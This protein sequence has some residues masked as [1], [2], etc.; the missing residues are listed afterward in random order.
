MNNGTRRQTHP[1]RIAVVVPR[2]GLVGGGEK[3][4]Y[5]LTERIARDYPWEIHVFANQW[6]S[7]SDKIRFHHVPIL[8][9]P[10]FLGPLSFAHFVHR[11]IIRF[12]PDLI[13]THE[14]IFDAHVYSVHGIPHP[15]W[16]KQIRGKSHMS[17]FDLSLSYVERRLVNSPNCNHLLAVSSITAEHMRHAFDNLSGRMQIVPPGVDL[18][19]F[20]K[21]SKQECRQILRQQCGWNADDIILLFVGMNFEIKGLDRTMTAL[22]QLRRLNLSASVRLL[23]VGKGNLRKYTQMADSLGI[24]DSVV[25]MGAIKTQ[26]ERI[27][28][29][30]DIF[31]L[32]SQFDTFGLVVLEAMAA[33]LPVIISTMVGAKDIV[34]N[35]ENGYIIDPTTAEEA[36]PCIASA[37]DPNRYV[38]L[39]QNARN[40]AK[41]HS[42]SAMAHSVAGIYS[43]IL[44]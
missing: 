11:K 44:I 43:D 16:V 29:G 15:L 1:K 21:W 24:M 38:H 6:R 33:G 5:E 32:L 28:L 31:I 25:F 30:S 12:G 27:Y 18:T 14:R 41:N 37:L 19:P 17:L 40:T 20:S 36:S 34:R 26:I 8:R 3:F 39:S 22:A 13:H 42:W 23:V 4:V 9:F 10:R 7:A 2:Y 35:G